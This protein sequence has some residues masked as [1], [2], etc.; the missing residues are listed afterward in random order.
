MPIS[1]RKHMLWVVGIGF[2]TVELSNLICGFRIAD[3]CENFSRDSINSWE[4]VLPSYRFPGIDQVG[5]MTVSVSGTIA[6]GVTGQQR[7]VE[8]E[9]W[10]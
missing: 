8:F 1:S 6:S 9:D 3:K 7:L 4:S 2:V 10:I 5:G